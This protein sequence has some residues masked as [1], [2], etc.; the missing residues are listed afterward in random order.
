MKPLFPWLVSCYQVI[1]RQNSN[2]SYKNFKKMKIRKT[3][4]QKVNEIIDFI[5]VYILTV[6]C[7]HII[8][9]TDAS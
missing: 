3:H 9:I 1:I 8:V 5:L 7:A 2:K 6:M 4:T